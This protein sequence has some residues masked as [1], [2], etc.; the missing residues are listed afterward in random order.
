MAKPPARPF[1]PAGGG[2]PSPKGKAPAGKFGKPA[3]P[4]GVSKPTGGAPGKKHGFTKHAAGHGKGKP[5]AQAPAVPLS[6]CAGPP[7]RR[8]CT[9]SKSACRDDRLTTV[10]VQEGSEGCQEEQVR[11]HQ[12]ELQHHPGDLMA[13][14][15]G[16]QAA[17]WPR[18]LNAFTQRLSLHA[19]GWA[20]RMLHNCGR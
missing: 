9:A 11:S 1:K 10:A 16:M 13:M 20:F 8:R 2:K 14:P 15:K 17:R 3:R 6:R 19:R 7:L 5:P 12:E 4:A 18:P